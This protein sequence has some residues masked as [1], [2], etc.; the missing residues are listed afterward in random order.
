VHN[1]TRKSP[2]EGEVIIS[3]ATYGKKERHLTKGQRPS[4]N[5]GGNASRGGSQQQIFMSTSWKVKKVPQNQS[6]QNSPN[7]RKIHLKD[8]VVSI[9]VTGG[10]VLG[11]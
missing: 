11:S 2:E 7:K 9:G 10:K 5:S 3:T 8:N 6:R 4:S 1:D